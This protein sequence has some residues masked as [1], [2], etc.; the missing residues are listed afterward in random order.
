MRPARTGGRSPAAALLIGL[1]AGGALGALAV[2]HLVSRLD[3]E[4]DHLRR[5]EEQLL[6]RLAAL[7]AAKNDFMATV[8]HELRTPLTSISGYVELLRDSE[9]GELTDAQRR[10]L[11]VIARNARRLRELIEDILTLS[12]I[13]SGGFASEPGDLDLAEVIERAVSAVAPTA[14]KA[15]V[16]LHCDVRGPLPIRG[17]GAQLDRVLANLVGN[18]IKFTPPEG[19]VTIRAEHR[20]GHTLLTVSDTGMGIPAAEQTALFDRFFRATNAIR[21]AIPGTGL[22]LAICQK[23]VDSHG[24][25]IEVDSTE[26]V[27]TTVR[28]RLPD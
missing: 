19:T 25:S 11:E 14:D 16:G 1:A 3:A 9:P 17:D 22:G 7:D 4:T 27:G 23:I 12:R 8:S 6:A 20:D 24:G 18:A 5:N 28:I 26:N 2:A 13:E 10:M 15:S 21:Q